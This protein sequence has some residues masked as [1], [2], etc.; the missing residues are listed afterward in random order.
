M[1]ASTFFFLA[2]FAAM[3][4]SGRV[5][6]RVLRGVH[7][8]CDALPACCDA[9]TA[10]ARPARQQPDP[11][12]AAVEQQLR[13][14]DQR[15]R[16]V[17]RSLQSISQSEHNLRDMVR[18][19]PEDGV[20]QELDAVAAGGRRLRELKGRLEARRVVLQAQ[21][22]M[23]R[24]GFPDEID[25]EAEGRASPVDALSAAALPVRDY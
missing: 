9:P 3:V 12:V 14:V 1:R 15:S 24:A 17:E 6:C 5:R 18:R 19:H 16:D 2:L 11:R 20:E 22:E 8:A 7:D 25:G 23:A 13:G 21:L 10:R 4:W